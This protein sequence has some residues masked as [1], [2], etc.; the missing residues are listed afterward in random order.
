[1]FSDER[2]VD[3]RVMQRDEVADVGSMSRPVLHARQMECRYEAGSY[4][5]MN[6][7]YAPHRRL[8]PWMRPSKRP[9]S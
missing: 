9:Q 2:M 6:P 7:G 3:S 5:S 4:L 1:M 8:L